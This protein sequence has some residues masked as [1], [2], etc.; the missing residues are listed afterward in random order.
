MSAKV[1]VHAVVR[2]L[3]EGDCYSITEDPGTQGI[4]E[5]SDAEKRNPSRGWG[6]CRLRGGCESGGWLV[7]R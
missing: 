1:R 3:L 6:F 2:A 4:R 7:V 5:R